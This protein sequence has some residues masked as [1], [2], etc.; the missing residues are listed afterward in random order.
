LIQAGQKQAEMV[1]SKY[2]TP[3]RSEDKTDI[4]VSHGN[5]IRYLVCRVLGGPA[6]GW[7][8]MLTFNCG[9][10]EIDIEPGGRLRL[11]RYNDLGHLPTELITEGMPKR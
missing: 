3:A 5:L 6:D 1:F 9:I 11:V 4:I 7:L 10:T 8:N 2:L